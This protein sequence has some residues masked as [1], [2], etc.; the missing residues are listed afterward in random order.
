MAMSHPRAARLRPDRVNGAALGAV[1]LGFYELGIQSREFD[2]RH[3]AWRSAQAYCNAVG[4]PLLRIGMRRSPLEP[5]NGDV[6]IDVDR[7][8][9][10]IP[11]GVQGDERAMQMFASKRFGVAFN[12]HTMEHLDA[13]ED[14]ALA[15]A[16]CLRVADFGYFL[17]P[18]AASIVANLHPTH[19]LQLEAVAGGMQVRRLHRAEE[20]WL[21]VP[22]PN[23]AFGTS[24]SL[25]I[26]S[27]TL[28]WRPVVESWPTT[29]D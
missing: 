12:E 10:S 23:A 21:F 29:Q 16:E 8:V 25:V 5:P 24:G 3:S 2:E 13:P 28:S 22:V 14:V 9:L 1:L 11:G 18:S 7:V 27:K 26:G 15:V 20:P 6:T 19:H 17:F 4:K